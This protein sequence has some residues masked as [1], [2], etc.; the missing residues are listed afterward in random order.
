MGGGCNNATQHPVLV[1]Q[2]IY[3]CVDCLLFRPVLCAP[4]TKHEC[5]FPLGEG[6]E[7]NTTYVSPSFKTLAAKGD[8]SFIRQIHS[9][10]SLTRR[11]GMSLDLAIRAAKVAMQEVLLKENLDGMPFAYESKVQVYYTH[12]LC[13]VKCGCPQ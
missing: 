1:Q 9:G 8:R 7:K 10:G 5:L 11:R 4:S 6:W 2:N 13:N 3:K 12:A